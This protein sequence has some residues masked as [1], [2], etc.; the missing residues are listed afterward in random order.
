MAEVRCPMCGKLNPAELE[1]CQFCHARLKPLIIEP[2]TEKPLESSQDEEEAPD[3]LKDLRQDPHAEADD[4][5]PSEGL[6]SGSD[7]EE[8][9][10]SDWL[11]S[12][13]FAAGEEDDESDEDPGQ[14]E[15]EEDW[16]GRLGDVEA[17][18]AGA[19]ESGFEIEDKFPTQEAEPET[20]VPAWLTHDD[21]NEVSDE[22]SEEESSEEPEQAAN[23]LGLAD[24][25]G[26]FDL[27]DWL[28]QTGETGEE[29]GFDP[30]AETPDWL[31]DLAETEESSS[32]EPEDSVEGEL[33]IWPGSLATEAADQRQP[34]DTDIQADLSSAEA[35]VEGDQ[36][37]D[38]DFDWLD[39]PGAKDEEPGLGDLLA[40]GGLAAGLAGSS[41]FSGEEAGGEDE[42]L[43]AELPDWFD[44]LQAGRPTLP[45]SKP[46]DGSE[47]EDSEQP[48]EPGLE[49]AELP[50]WLEAIRPV[51]AEPGP[52]IVSG[53]DEDVSVEGAGPLAGLSGVLPAEPE[54]LR[55][56]KPA[57]YS[58]KL[59]ITEQQQEH[60]ALLA[61]LVEAEGLA[62]P[63]PTKAVLSAQHIL[64]LVIGLLLIAAVL[65]P[66]LLGFPQASL[67]DA[68]AG[69][70]EFSQIVNQL[71]GGDPVLL[72]FD[73]IPAASGEMDAVIAPV[74]EHM[75]IEGAYLTLIST[76]P[77]GPL[78]G[79]RL[80]ERIRQRSGRSFEPGTQYTNLGFIPGG[81]AGLVSFALRPR[82]TSP[83]SIQEIS[84]QNTSSAWDELPLSNVNT[85]GDFALVMVVTENP[86]VARIW[87]EQV[88]PVL[89]DTP[90]L[91]AVSAQAE[92]MVRPYYQAG[93]AQVQGTVAGISGGVY[94]SYF[95]FRQEPAVFWDAYSLGAW[96]AI[97]LILV[98][99]LTN[100]VFRISGRGKP[101]PTVKKAGDGSKS[102]PQAESDAAQEDLA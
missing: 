26:T 97:V 46:L 40:A 60:A 81:Q 95:Q 23:D 68:P 13:R 43:P 49:P 56:S 45:A 48:I 85:L 32:D 64:R 67:P 91:L 94:Y 65:I 14:Q 55:V 37:A 54:I 19:E 96:A 11:S 29:S 80:L 77:T 50:S 51:G 76:N 102:K 74:I 16:L 28:A 86:D 24:S 73:Y 52:G 5:D 101:P 59:Q 61:K 90:L 27:P 89:A 31:K 18:D 78:Q 98:G 10:G 47:I 83:I 69:L 88:G 72:A 100:L 36:V 21:L 70:S 71:N 84:E 66:L 7:E 25:A 35:P 3:W 2:S 82:E 9:K 20:E 17:P 1:E 79:E 38:D 58:V 44:E 22:D 42:L 33:P 75:M 4:Y 57:T 63:L 92:P 8:N 93:A 62:Q 99:G 87:I 39:E 34:A 15:Y 6:K 53:L 12:M 41:P 30:A